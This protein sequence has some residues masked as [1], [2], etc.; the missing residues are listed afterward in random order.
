M[1]SQLE[2]F[3][4][5]GI[6]PT[7]ENL[8]GESFDKTLQLIQRTVLDRE[9]SAI[10][11]SIGTGKTTTA[12]QAIR[13]LSKQIDIE[14]VELLIP[15]RKG[16]STSHLLNAF[17]RTLGERYD[18][19]A[20]IRRRLDARTAQ[21]ERILMK[22][23]QK[24]VVALLVIDEAQELESGTLNVIK[25]LRDVSFIK[26]EVMLPVLLIGQP[27]VFA[28]LDRNDEVSNRVRRKNRLAFQPTRGELLNIILYK[29]QGTLEPHLAEV[30]LD[31][32]TK[33]KSGKKILPT[34]LELD[35]YLEEAM[36]NA[37]NLEEKKLELHHFNF[38]VGFTRKK[39]VIDRKGPTMA[40][41]SDSADAIET[42]AAS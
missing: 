30:V 15:D 10:E 4:N 23:A 40:D 9:W 17:V 42:R 27:G 8:E 3:E 39:S 31:N 7:Q 33:E 22:M 29:T 25:R 14:V 16:I 12:Y 38:P 20:S 36:E 35:D 5:L 2:I 32:F 19:D 28:L 13:A 11:G 21:V 24:D 1:S 37:L 18:G 41:A 26:K 6:K 34:P